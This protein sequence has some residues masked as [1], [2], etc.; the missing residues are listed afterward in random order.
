MQI[1][2]EAGWSAVAFDYAKRLEPYFF[3]VMIFF[4]FCHMVIVL[5]LAT[6]LKGIVWSVFSTVS[7][8]FEE[9]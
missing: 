2:T 3:I 9:R 1:L 8:Q 6:L 5:V 4:V 7:S